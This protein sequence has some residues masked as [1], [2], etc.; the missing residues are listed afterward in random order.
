M[1]KLPSKKKA[2]KPKTAPLPG[3]WYPRRRGILEHLQNGR[4]LLIDLAVHDFLCLTCDHKSG[5]VISSARKIAS[6]APAEDAT[7]YRRIKRSLE[8]LEAIGWIKR[9]LPAKGT[10]GNYPIVI[11][12]FYVQRRVPDVSLTAAPSLS[13]TLSLKWFS[14]NAERTTDWH[15]IQYDLV[16]DGVPDLV[17][18]AD[19]RGVPSSRRKKKQQQEVKQ[20]QEVAFT[21]SLPQDP[22]SSSSDTGDAKPD[23]DRSSEKYPQGNPYVQEWAEKRILERAQDKVL[24]RAAY[25][26]V[27]LPKFLDNLDAEIDLYLVERLTWFIGQCLYEC[28]DGGV[29]YL[30]MSIFLLVQCYEYD[31]RVTKSDLMWRPYCSDRAEKI[32]ADVFANF[33]G[34][35]IVHD[36]LGITVTPQYREQRLRPG[37]VPIRGWQP[38]RALYVSANAPKDMIFLVDAA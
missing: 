11:A 12:R 13:L 16:P 4:I 34:D 3:G 36:E 30:E 14:V 33:Q 28:P 5:L 17:S 15:D 31:L 7:G 9:W 20:E 21:E 23:D 10:K 19:P 8:R 22:S 27:A 25:L 6:L 38:W 32:Y 18:D 24:D 35:I 37:A 29:S 26:Y 1:T 2:V